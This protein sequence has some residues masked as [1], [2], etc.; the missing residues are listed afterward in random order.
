VFLCTLVNSSVGIKDWQ[1]MVPLWC[2]YI[3]V[4]ARRWRNKWFTLILVDTCFSKKMEKQMVHFDSCRYVFQQK[5]LRNHSC[6]KW[7]YTF[8][9]KHGTTY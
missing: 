7:G 3:C 4:S 5:K 8:A 1:Q 6:Y 2:L 9:V